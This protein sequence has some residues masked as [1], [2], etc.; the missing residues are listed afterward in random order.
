MQLKNAHTIHQIYITMRKNIIVIGDVVLDK[1]I[2]LLPK[3]LTYEKG[4]AA[5]TV[6]LY[7]IVHIDKF[8]GGAYNVAYY[9]QNK[10]LDNDVFFYTALPINYRQYISD[11]ISYKCCDGNLKGVLDIKQRQAVDIFSTKEEIGTETA[12][13]KDRYDYRVPVA[14]YAEND[15]YEFVKNINFHDADMV[16][17]SDYRKGFFTKKILQHII[18]NSKLVIVDTKNPVLEDYIGA[19]YIKLNLS[20]YIE[21]TN[22]YSDKLDEI[23]SMFKMIVTRG[24]LSTV[25]AVPEIED[26][27]VMEISVDVEHVEQ[28][29]IRDTIGAG[30]AF[31]AGFTSGLLDTGDA[32]AA[33]K[34]GHKMAAI[35]LAHFGT[36]WR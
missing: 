26:K 32:V 31:V 21:I 25:Y 17:I 29:Y 24:A 11:N 34:E 19:N 35:K 28:Q 6:P 23:T 3:N 2:Y 13:I 4:K 30:D 20:E 15:I 33:I 5:E 14:K 12:R 22:L 9:L 36:Q 16:V 10:L 18:A 8:L 1:Y 7:D 27:T